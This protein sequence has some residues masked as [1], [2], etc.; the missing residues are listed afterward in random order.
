[1]LRRGAISNALAW[2]EAGIIGL[3]MIAVGCL[4]SIDARLGAQG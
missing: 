2:M 3:L 1:M 4:I